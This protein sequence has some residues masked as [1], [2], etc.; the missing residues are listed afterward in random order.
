MGL[1]FVDNSWKI[2]AKKSCALAFWLYTNDFN[3]THR[4]ET[5]KHLEQY[6]NRVNFARVHFHKKPAYTIGALTRV[7]AE[8]IA[9][10][11]CCDASPENVTC[12]GE[13]SRADVQAKMRLYRNAAAD[14]LSLYPMIKP[15]WDDMGL[16]DAA[17]EVKSFIVGDRV[18]INHPKL[19]GYAEGKVLKVNRVKCRVEFAKGTFNVPFSMMEKV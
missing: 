16:F 18:S 7:D 5:M 4:S 10:S 1:L 8:A 19:G 2:L 17:P 13:A 6:L 11:L 15:Q 9:E 12:D 3:N 14:L